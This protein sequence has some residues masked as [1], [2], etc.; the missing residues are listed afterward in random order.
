MIRLCVVA[1]SAGVL[2]LSAPALANGHDPVTFCHNVQ[3]PHEITTDNNGH[4]NGHVNGR[5]AHDPQDCDTST[6]TQ[7]PSTP[8][9]PG[10]PGS[11]GASGASST[12]VQPAQAVNVVPTGLTG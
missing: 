7:P 11:P 3:H 4:D 2:A 6:P 5:G 10:V 9:T 1:A 8:G 12:A